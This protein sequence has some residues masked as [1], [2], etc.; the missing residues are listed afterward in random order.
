MS[1]EREA[2]FSGD[3]GDEEPTWHLHRQTEAILSALKDGLLLV[4]AQGRVTHANPVA[5][6]MLGYE[7]A[8]LVGMSFPTLFAEP[9]PGSERQV[10]HRRLL[11]AI[12]ERRRATEPCARVRRK[13]GSVFPA[14]VR[15]APM[16]EEERYANAVV[17]LRDI[18]DRVASQEEQRRLAAILEATPDYVTSADPLGRL[19]Y[20]NATVRA[21]AGGRRLEG[22]SIATLL[23]PSSAQDVLGLG[24]ST[25]LD[26]G[27]WQGETTI[28][29]PDG[30][31]RIL[32]QV[33][34]AHRSSEGELLGLSSVARDVTAEKRAER[35]QRFLAEASRVLSAELELEATL[36]QVAHL[37]IPFFSDI[38]FVAM[39][40]E[41]ELVQV[42]HAHRHPDQRHLVERLADE[43]ASDSVVGLH[44]VLRSG[45]A[46]LVPR[47]TDAWI[48]AAAGEPAYFERIRAL[49]LRSLLIQPLATRGRRLGVIA[50]GSLTR[51]FTDEDRLLGEELAARAAQAVENARLYDESVAATRLR[52]E[53]LNVVSHDLRNPL[54]SVTLAARSLLRSLDAPDQQDARGQAERILNA[55]ERAVRLIED[56]LD[57]AKIEGAGLRM[58]KRPT[59]PRDLVE[60]AVE[61]HRPL[62]EAS[63][64]HIEAG[65]E[66]PLP[67]IEVDRDR[68]QQVL[69]NLIGNAIKFSP[70]GGRIEV[71]VAARDDRVEF[72]VA[73]TG[74]GIPPE[75]LPHVF[76]RFW[77]AS[78]RR[79]SIGLG[80]AISRGIVSFHGGD[81]D[82]A[83]EPGRGTT[84]TFWIPVPAGD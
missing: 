70:E 11:E 59:S 73:D 82:V 22:A 40:R 28:R 54:T 63:H 61:V 38:C 37:P 52:E 39:A 14:E 16:H 15:T 68:M 79:G 69:S 56:L 57:V 77:Q 26:L 42:A 33:L 64:L 60:E 78:Q 80:L 51:N 31:E 19:V 65:V 55:T 76:D 3:S 29:L 45:V 58:E 46:E 41:G 35:G 18:T 27:S 49:G 67:E 47:V 71:R 44:A 50:F 12:D 2:P 30:S 32:S 7:L 25:A 83:S 4:D 24:I 21:A 10:E 81:I 53:V 36:D 34:I 5:R 84:F 1:G 20:T 23:T 6:E 17:T 75:H 62:A 48:W 13:D 9:K 66:E 72:A 8:E 43:G 74:R